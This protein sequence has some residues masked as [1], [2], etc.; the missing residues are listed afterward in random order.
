MV[1]CSL[2]DSE[3]AYC[4]HF[5]KKDNMNET[6][7]FITQLCGTIDWDSATKLR[8]ECLGFF[9][10]VFLFKVRAIML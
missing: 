3:L 9:H 2:R 1:L 10:I 6:E 7:A 8:N 5:E 4:P